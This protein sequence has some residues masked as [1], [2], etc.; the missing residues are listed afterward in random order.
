MNK[1]SSAESHMRDEVSKFRCGLNSLMLSWVV[2][3][4]DQQ[5]TMGPAEPEGKM[6]ERNYPNIEVFPEMEL[7]R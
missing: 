7:T 3:W 5:S 6:W 2:L 1:H 4:K